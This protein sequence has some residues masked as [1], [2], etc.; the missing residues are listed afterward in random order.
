MRNIIILAVFC[1]LLRCE[2]QEELRVDLI[3]M[4]T[5]R[6]VTIRMTNATS[7]YLTLERSTN[8]G[9]WEGLSTSKAAATDFVDTGASYRDAAFYRALAV[10]GT[11]VLTGDILP[12]DNGNLTIH[13][14]NHASFVM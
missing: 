2:A 5:N 1:C 8:A 11:N 7:P 6:D 13:P 12:T 4:A 9:T 10:E 14:V 3:Q